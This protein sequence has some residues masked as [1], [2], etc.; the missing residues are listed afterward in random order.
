MALA[1]HRDPLPDD[2]LAAS[3]CA[4]ACAPHEDNNG[5]LLKGD[6]LLD[7]SAWGEGLGWFGSLE[8]DAVGPS[9]KNRLNA[10]V[11]VGGI[12]TTVQLPSAGLNWTA[13]PNVE[14]GYWL[15]QGAGALAVSYRGIMNA[16]GSDT[17][18]PFAVLGNAGALTSH[19]SMN[20]IDF[21]YASRENSLGPL[22]DMRWR[23][24]IRIATVFF[25]STAD[26]LL[27]T[28]H[29]SNNFV[30]GGVHFGLDLK[31]R[32]GDTGF[33]LL[34]HVDGGVVLGHVHQ[35][36]EEVIAGAGGAA[37]TSSAN[38]PAPNLQVRLGLE[39]APFQFP[40]VRFSAGYLFE[41]WWT[42]GETFGTYGEVTTQGVFLRGEWRY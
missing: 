1:D 30:G 27:L 7:G 2:Q 29:E 14:I 23:T 18:V 32:F 31:R 28:Q 11:V 21:D 33:A 17:L 4:P 40:D 37:T 3:R 35:L 9:V 16:S 19:L 39:W 25:D 41:R 24:G 12:L 22:W 6:P 5:R 15:G 42:V 38:E 8:A 10:P 20:V 34:G 26:S 13:M 36:Y